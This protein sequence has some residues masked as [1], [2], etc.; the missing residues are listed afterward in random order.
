MFSERVWCVASNR[1]SRRPIHH[2]S[3]R[4][5]FLILGLENRLVAELLPREPLHAHLLEERLEGIRPVARRRAGV[6]LP[7]GFVHDEHGLRGVVPTNLAKLRRVPVH[8]Q[9]TTSVQLPIRAI[10]KITKNNQK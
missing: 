5:N 2:Q 4:Q 7:T 6:V 1:P 10:T 3:S 8:K 9:N